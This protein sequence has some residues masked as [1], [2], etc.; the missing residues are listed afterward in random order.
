M[1][2]KRALAWLGRAF[3]LAALIY[4]AV[5][6][7]RQWTTLS[8]WRLSLAD[9]G[10]MVVSAIG[11]GAALFLVAEAWHRLVSN[12]ASAPLSRTLT[13]PSMG[14]TQIAKYLPGNVLHLVGRHAWLSRAG[15]SHAALARAAAWEAGCLVVAAVITAS[16]LAIV[17]PPQIN[18]PSVDVRQAAVLALATLLCGVGLAALLRWR[19]ALIRRWTPSLSV[20]AGAVAILV[21]FFLSQ[22]SI[23]MLLM[24]AVDA[25][26]TPEVLPI[27]V[28]AWL[29]GFLTPGAPGGLGTREF[30]L[31][32]LMSPL[33]GSGKALIVT[34]LFRLVT[35]LGD[36]ICFLASYALTRVTKQ[37]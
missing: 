20:A 16:L 29:V 13:V 37:G 36:V 8:A 28:V 27:P 35:T 14:V 32:T 15:V 30:I 17:W 19:F 26:L 25:H 33:L 23:F 2:L 22:G 12:S 11:Y 1:S 6:I 21:I 5:G 31:S 18:L 34:A 4:L 24:I 10:L 9:L 7:G 3:S